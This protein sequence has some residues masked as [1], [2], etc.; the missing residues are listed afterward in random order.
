MVIKMLKY[1]FEK[2]DIISIKLFAD[3]LKSKGFIMP[4]DIILEYVRNPKYALACS[5]ALHEN[6]KMIFCKCPPTYDIVEKEYHSK[7][8]WQNKS[9]NYVSNAF[10]SHVANSV[11]NLIPFCYINLGICT[12]SKDEYKYGKMSLVRYE[13]ELASKGIKFETIE[14]SIEGSKIYLLSNRRNNVKK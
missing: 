3:Y 14:D 13:K 2:E 11:S 4:D 5:K 6:D 12:S 10:N 7:E 8:A 9:I 1:D